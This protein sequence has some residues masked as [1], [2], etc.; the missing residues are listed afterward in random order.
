[1]GSQ[2]RSGDILVILPKKLPGKKT[3]K[4]RAM[5]DRFSEAAKEE[6]GDRIEY[7]KILGINNNALG[8]WIAM[9]IVKDLGGVEEVDVFVAG[10]RVPDNELLERHRQMLDGFKLGG[11]IPKNLSENT[12]RRMRG[13]PGL[14][15]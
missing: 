10:K 11:R 6:A 7:R 3:A 13:Q 5:V 12:K 4:I 1:M 2:M 15:S 8:F 14:P 9:D